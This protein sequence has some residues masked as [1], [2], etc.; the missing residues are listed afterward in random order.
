MLRVKRN[1]TKLTRAQCT[2]IDEIRRVQRYA[3][4]WAIEQFLQD[5]ILSAYDCQKIYTVVRPEWTKHVQRVWQNSAI[6]EAR[7]AADLSYKYGNGELKYRSRKHSNHIAVT[8]YGGRPE[9][10]GDKLHLPLFG[11]VVLPDGLP[12]MDGVTTC[13][14]FV[15][16]S[17]SN[18]RG[19]PVC[20]L[21]IAY[22][23]QKPKQ[24]T[25]GREVGIDRGI[26]NPTVT[27]DSDGNVY[28]YDTVKPFKEGRKKSQK[29]QSR[30]S[31]VRKGS[32]QYKKLQAKRAK[33]NRDVTN[34]R[35]Y[36]EWLLA[37]E[38]C[39]DMKLVVLEDLRISAMTRN[40]GNHKKW[41]NREFR[42]VRHS[43]IVRKIEIVAE[44]LGIE[45]VRV[46]PKNTSKECHR[47]K[48][49][50][51]R[52]REYFTCETCGAYHADGNAAV[53]ILQKGG[54]RCPTEVGITFVRRELL[55]SLY[56]EGYTNTS[57]VFEQQVEPGG[58]YRSIPDGYGE[59][60]IGKATQRENQACPVPLSVG[61]LSDNHF[62][63]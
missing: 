39:R 40:G 52:E 55:P 62:S 18:N 58:L 41:L 37:K 43:A 26:V 24:N 53:N 50:G 36:L 3:Y 31:K 56:G 54:G 7:R 9:I 8:N 30:M 61:N 4:N 49:K 2:K 21:R 19:Q 35:D 48:V 33:H 22:N 34:R 27:A 59:D 46:N 13:Y 11:D 28:C 20:S 10:R 14:S 51:M 38:I 42:F 5:P 60:T 44:R 15:D 63:I 1:R 6:M 17:P 57:G 32:V 25:T 45:V 12:S 16:V 47:C 29:L 23:I